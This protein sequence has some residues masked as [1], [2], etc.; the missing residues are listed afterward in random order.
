MNAHEEGNI[1]YSNKIYMVYECRLDIRNQK[2]IK[3]FNY[4]LTNNI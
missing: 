1:T 2:E 3:I 4:A